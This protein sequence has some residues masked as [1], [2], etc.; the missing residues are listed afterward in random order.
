[1]P[2][3]PALHLPIKN[4]VADLSIGNGASKQ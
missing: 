4:H 3:I 2:M 1:V